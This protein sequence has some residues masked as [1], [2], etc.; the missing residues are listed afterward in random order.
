MLDALREG[1]YG[2]GVWILT[3]L[4]SDWRE[5]RPRKWHGWPL[6][7]PPCSLWVGDGVWEGPRGGLPGPRLPCGA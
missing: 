2:I 1:H 4:A 5:N 6:S 3:L 7:Y